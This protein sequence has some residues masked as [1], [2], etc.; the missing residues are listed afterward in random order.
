MSGIE[1]SLKVQEKDEYHLPLSR[2]R[3]ELEKSRHD[4]IVEMLV[5]FILNVLHFM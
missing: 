4:A 3:A 2:K 5:G 1:R